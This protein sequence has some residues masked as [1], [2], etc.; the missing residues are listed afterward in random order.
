MVEACKGDNCRMA[1]RCQ[2]VREKGVP[3]RTPYNP[4]IGTCEHFLPITCQ[5]RECGKRYTPKRTDQR[6][7]CKEHQAKEQTLRYNEQRANNRRA[8]YQTLECTCG[9]TFKQTH[10]AQLTC[11]DCLDKKYTAR[12]L[13]KEIAKDYKDCS[14]VNKF[15]KAP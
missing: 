8:A 2:R 13:A 10:K 4:H 14:T 15:L 11:R 12:P 6:Y 5:Y 7:C 9:E 1:E 3:I